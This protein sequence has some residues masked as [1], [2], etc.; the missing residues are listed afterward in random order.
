[1]P[2]AICGHAISQSYLYIRSG[3]MAQSGPHIARALKGWYH[4]SLPSWPISAWQPGNAS[5]SGLHV[6][7]CKSSSCTCHSHLK[8]ISRRSRPVLHGHYLRPAQGQA[9]PVPAQDLSAHMCL[10][11]IVYR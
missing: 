6:V 8:V 7:P 9:R 3:T 11:H 10:M 5:S 2:I 1:M 4:S